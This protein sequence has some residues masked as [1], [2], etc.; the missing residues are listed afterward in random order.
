MSIFT[1]LYILASNQTVSFVHFCNRYVQHIKMRAGWVLSIPSLVRFC[2]HMMR[3]KVTIH[4]LSN[5]HHNIQ[6]WHKKFLSHV[7]PFS[8][9]MN[10]HSC[11]LTDK[12]APFHQWQNWFRWK[13]WQVQKNEVIR[14]IAQPLCC[15]SWLLTTIFLYIRCASAKRD[16]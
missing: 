9:T 5:H 1:F 10:S 7:S 14:I 3:V 16:S 6:M 13:S 8:T 11:F 12:Y 2:D 15:Y 4:W